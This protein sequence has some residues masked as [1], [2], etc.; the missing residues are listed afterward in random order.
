MLERKNFKKI[1]KIIKKDFKLKLL[2]LGFG[3]VMWF[4][5]IGGINPIVVRQFKDIPVKYKNE[6]VLERNNFLITEPKKPLVNVSIKGTRNDV[7]AINKNDIIAEINLDSSITAGT[8]RLNVNVKVPHSVEIASVSE[9]EILVS[10]DEEITKTFDVTVE[11]KGEI[12]NKNQVVVKKEP[13]DKFVMLTGPA[14][15]VKKVKKVLA[16]VDVTGKET[17]EV[18]IAKLRAVDEN[19]KV[20]EQVELSK[21]DTNVSIGFKNF[22]EVPINLVEINT[23][24]NDIM[25]LKKNLVPKVV[26]I[27]GN[28]TSLEKIKEIKTKPFDLSQVKDSKVYDL[29]LDLPKDITLVNKDLKPVVNI[30]VDKKLEKVLSVKTEDISIQGV[31]DDV[32]LQG[33]NDN[34]DVTVR[35]YESYISNLKPEDIKLYIDINSTDIGKN[36]QIKAKALDNVE[37]VK[38]SNDIVKVIAK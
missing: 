10:F 28:T 4:F 37:I 21:T 20:I 16:I 26:S 1:L 2:C 19:E 11:T 31:S 12:K 25:I 18:V 22:K 7:Y 17:D 9:H 8:H 32:I 29:T 33:L 3:I 34:V 35:G 38:I 15:Y 36:V 5:V 23:A 27:V 14:S 30:D 6:A 24:S 13:D